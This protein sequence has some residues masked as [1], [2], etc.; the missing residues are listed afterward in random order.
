MMQGRLR[1]TAWAGRSNEELSDMSSIPMPRFCQN[2]RI[3][4]TPMRDSGPNNDLSSQLVSELLKFYLGPSANLTPQV[5]TRGAFTAPMMQISIGNCLA[6]D[7]MSTELHAQTGPPESIKEARNSL[8]LSMTGYAKPGGLRSHDSRLHDGVSDSFRLE[9]YMDVLGSK[10]TRMSGGLSMTKYE[11]HASACDRQLEYEH[12]IH[13]LTKEDQRSPL[14]QYAR[15]VAK[16]GGGLSGLTTVMLQQIPYQYMQADFMMEI[17]R[18]GFEGTFDFL[19]L[20]MSQKRHGNIGFGFINFL[21]SSFA[22]KF[23]RK[24]QGQ[25]LECYDA[26]TTINVVPADVQGFEQSVAHF[27]SH[28]QLRKRKRLSVPVFLKPIPAHLKQEVEQKIESC[29]H[30]AFGARNEDYNVVAE[31]AISNNALC[32]SSSCEFA[33]EN[34][35]STKGRALLRL[36]F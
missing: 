16:A 25:R 17:N 6:Q 34:F 24:Y 35:D 32:S 1:P 33:C 2:E 10:S 29:V 7:M 11:A 22:E 14:M 36:S 28:W 8:G 19:F 12:G 31:K 13:D 18:Q 27:Y 15:D 20:P 4:M 3:S 9:R 30:D 5:H 21:S 23:Y 26:R